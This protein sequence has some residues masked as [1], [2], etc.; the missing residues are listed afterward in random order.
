MNILGMGTME[1]LIILLVAFIFLGPERMVDAARLLGKAAREARR[2]SASLGE[3]VLDDDETGPA[4]PRDD[5]YARGSFRGGPSEAARTAAGPE[6]EA[7]PAV[8]D[9]PVAYRASTT[10][11]AEDGPGPAPDQER[12]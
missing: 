10:A 6:P 4:N 7:S 3:I 1:V 12:G 8:D 5:R 2:M 11:G 9:S